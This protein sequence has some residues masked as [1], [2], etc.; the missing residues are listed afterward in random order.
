[1]SEI[2]VTEWL[3][4]KAQLIQLNESIAQVDLDQDGELELV[5]AYTYLNK[6]H[7][8]ILKQIKQTMKMI[9]NYQLDGKIIFFKNAYI[10]SEHCKN[11]IIGLNKQ[12][13][14]NELYLLG[15]KNGKYQ[16][17]LTRDYYFHLIEVE[18][19]NDDHK[20]EIALWLKNTNNTYKIDVYR[21]SKDRLA[22]ALDFYE[23]YFINVVYYYRQL[24]VNDYEKPVYLY[25]LA[26]SQMK[27]NMPLDAIDTIDESLRLSNPYPSKE[28]LVD[29]KEK[30]EDHTIR[31]RM[32][33]F[34]A[35]INTV[36]GKK[37][38]F[39]NNKGQFVINPQFDEVKPFNNRGI[40]IVK[41]NERFGT[42]NKLGEYIIKPKYYSIGEYN[43]GRSVVLNDEGNKVVDYYGSVITDQ[44]YEY[45]GTYHYGRAVFA[46]VMQD[47]QILQGY[48]DREG[49]EIIPAQYIEAS[50]FNDGVG[51]VKL[52]N[53]Q[54][55]TINRQGDQLYAYDYVYVGEY[56]E[57]TL[58]FRP[59][60]GFYGYMDIEG[61]VFIKPTYN[62]AKSFINNRAIV[63]TSTT[64]VNDYGLINREGKEIIETSYNDIIRLG[65]E[66]FAIGQALNKEKPFLGSVYAIADLDGNFLSEFI[67]NNITNY[68]NGLAS[69]TFDNKTLF[70]DKM[71]NVVKALPVLKGTGT[72]SIEKELIKADIDRE[73]SY[74][75]LYGRLV[76]QPNREIPLVSPYRIKMEKYKPNK[77][78]LVYYPQIHGM[79]NKEI[80]KLVNQKLKEQS[81]VKDI[82]VNEKLDYRYY[83]DFEIEYF[84]S[85][86]LVLCLIGYHYTYGAA[87]G[88]PTQ[89][90]V[91]L[92]LETGEMY[93]LSDLFKENSDYVKQINHII[94]TQIKQDDEYSYVFKDAFETIK[95]NQPFFV[96]HS[97]LNIYFKPYEIAPYYAGFPT[98]NIPYEQ[99]I[100]MIDLD[101]TFWRA[102]QAKK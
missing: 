47:K 41:L 26:T 19:I 80:Q 27:A 40:A 24:H 75:D 7:I 72:L 69:A 13:D 90:Y 68:H 20:C 78:Y 17:M 88:E 63:N 35:A 102:I 56:N 94:Q 99:I 12:K 2:K 49:N 71:G 45:I 33:L 81:Q 60:K 54:Y 9:I 34:E 15:F 1:M 101:G 22:F 43:E 14:Y 18:D 95:P 25:H 87:H 59:E 76:Y 36:N 53:N 23:D 86:L 52:K 73:I 6:D 62:Q 10:T 97:S 42:I 38:G 51:V 96:D 28:F 83:G 4:P 8:M 16:N 64:I 31:N 93:D 98:F 46:R 100:E 57:K 30:L 70:I 92:D 85:K 74:Y 58:I 29:M 55:V 21:W 77:D 37:W 39:I 84:N 91:N 67:Y 44:T 61:N 5:I 66:R 65:E 3:P 11:V 50:D 79:I 48:L 32:N 82:P 89:I